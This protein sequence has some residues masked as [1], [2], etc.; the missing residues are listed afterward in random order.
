MY[1]TLTGKDSPDYQTE[2]IPNP[3]WRCQGFNRGAF[4]YKAS[5]T[6]QQLLHSISLL[7]ISRKSQLY[8]LWTFL[9]FTVAAMLSGERS[10]WRPN[11]TMLTLCKRG[12]QGAT[13]GRRGEFSALNIYYLALQAVPQAPGTPYSLVRVTPLFWQKEKGFVHV[14]SFPTCSQPFQ[15]PNLKRSSLA[16][17]SWP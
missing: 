17:H 15:L 7:S 13:A 8:E 3:T 16:L 4:E 1:S 14:S 10:E 11:E 5:S 6:K 12:S 9:L 2:S